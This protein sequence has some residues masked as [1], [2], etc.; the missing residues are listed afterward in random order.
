MHSELVMTAVKALTIV[1]ARPQ[2]VKVAAV[3]RAFD[4][5]GLVQNIIVHTGQHFD[6]SMSGL[7]FEELMIDPPAYQLEISGGRHGSMTGRMMERVEPVLEAEMPDIVVIYGDTNSTLAGALVAAKL[8]I[9]VA[10]IEAGLRSFN[11]KMP[12]E[13]NRVVADHLSDL[14]LCPTKA[15]VDNLRDEGITEGVYHVGD[16]MYDATLAA[17]SRAAEQS[18]VLHRL[19]LEPKG[20]ALATVHRAE[21]TD[22]PSQLRKIMAYLSAAAAGQKVVLPLHPRTCIAM[23][24]IGLVPERVQMIDPVGYLDMQ[25]LISNASLVLTDSG[26]V[27]KEAYFHKVPCVTLRDE[28][29]WVETIEAGWNRLWRDPEYRSRVKIEE[30]GDGTS[31]KTCAKLIVQLAQNRL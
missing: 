20:F 12:E 7:F 4:E 18:D 14:L 30:Y 5:L 27:Q 26:G 22:S 2:F 8:H 25:Q 29:E 3:A 15:S 19:E 6:H 10:H 9:P 16:V 11:R 24:K 17:A 13:I 23:N 28:T 31:A 21:N 1:G